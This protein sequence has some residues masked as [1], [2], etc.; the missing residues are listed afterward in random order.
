MSAEVVWC[1]KCK[2]AVWAYD[3]T[4]PGR[5]IAGLMNQMSMICPECGAVRSFDGWGSASLTLEEVRVATQAPSQQIYDWWSA[6]KV[7]F[8]MNVKEGKWAI[9]PNCKWFERPDGRNLTNEVS[10]LVK[11]SKQ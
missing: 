4:S 2:T 6:L 11:A 9:S 10:A 8:R 7:V 1:N 5:G 3:E